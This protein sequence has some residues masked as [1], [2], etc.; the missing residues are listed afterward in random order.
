[1]WNC[2]PR[3]ICR[4]VLK[5]LLFRVLNYVPGIPRP[6]Q[7]SLMLRYEIFICFFHWVEEEI[8]FKLSNNCE[9]PR[10]VFDLHLLTA[11]LQTLYR[12]STFYR[13]RNSEIDSIIFL[14]LLKPK[15]NLLQDWFTMLKR[16]HLWS[17]LHLRFRK[18]TKITE[19]ISEY[20]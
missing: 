9:M 5:Q 6:C 11:A 14:F 10:D 2:S 19:S 8:N 17:I 4:V 16:S 12:G 3:H 7:S 1:M 13:T 20:V 18:K 15:C